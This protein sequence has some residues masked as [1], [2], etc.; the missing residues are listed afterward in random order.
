MDGALIIRLG[1]PDDCGRLAELVT[2]TGILRGPD[3]EVTISYAY[4]AP[5][6]DAALAEAPLQE[7]SHV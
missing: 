2:S 3:C 6:T 7:A 5:E 4:D 1:P